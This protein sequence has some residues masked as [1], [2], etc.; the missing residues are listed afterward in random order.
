MS[1]IKK[2][3]HIVLHYF[4]KHD[5][6][7]NITHIFIIVII[8]HIHINSN[9]FK[10]S[11]FSSNIPYFCSSEWSYL[12]IIFIC[13]P[14]FLWRWGSDDSVREGFVLNMHV[15]WG[16]VTSTF[17]LLKR[18]QW[19]AHLPEVIKKKIYHQGGHSIFEFTSLS[20]YYLLSRL[21]IPLWIDS[22]LYYSV[23][24]TVYYFW[25]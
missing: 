21:C 18:G 15:D 10:N 25:I 11:D 22:L 17:I 8:N 1:K 12:K 19:H 24:S 6:E 2:C 5:P 14:F 13:L 23:L 20:F 4:D 16:A 7:D 9:A 3:I